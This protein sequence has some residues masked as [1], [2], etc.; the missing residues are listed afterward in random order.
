MSP[1]GDL[2]N[3]YVLIALCFA[4][5]TPTSTPDRTAPRDRGDR[6]RGLNRYEVC[7]GRFASLLEAPIVAIASAR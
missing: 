1:F 3:L 2:Y 5:A 6:A 7:F 4:A